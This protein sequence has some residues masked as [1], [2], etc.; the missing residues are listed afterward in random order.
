LEKI[1]IDRVELTLMPPVKTD[2]EWVDYSQY[3]QQLQAAWL[4][5]S[6]ALRALS[7]N[8]R[9]F[10]L[11]DASIKSEGWIF[12]VPWRENSADAEL[13]REQSLEIERQLFIDERCATDREARVTFDHLAK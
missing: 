7:A 6:A 9:L 2:D 4:R 11:P 13:T 10:E 12:G 8:V 5:L 3:L 1:V